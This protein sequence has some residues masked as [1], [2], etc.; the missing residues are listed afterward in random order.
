MTK[1]KHRVLIHNGQTKTLYEDEM[2][3][4]LLESL[5]GKAKITRASHVEAPQG[6][7]SKIEFQADLSPSGGPIL[8]GFKTYKD[9]VEA[10]IAWI[11]GNTLN[12]KA[13]KRF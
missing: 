9:A 2:G 5:G 10:E 11:Q 7:L 6:E 3:G 13:H 1:P 12:P 4:K 8:K